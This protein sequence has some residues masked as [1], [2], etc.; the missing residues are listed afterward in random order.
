MADRATESNLKKALI[1]VLDRQGSPTDE[2]P[3][4]FNPDEY[5]LNKQVYH[6]DQNLPGRKTPVNQFVHGNA[7]SLSMDLFLDTYEEGTDVREYTD[8][9][10][11]LLEVDE[12]RHAP[13]VCRFVWGTLNFK[14]VLEQATMN[15]TMFRSNGI[16]VR[17]RVD[18]TF[19]EYK[20]PAEES[21]ARPRQSADR[22]KVWTVTEGDTLW[23]IAGEEYGDPGRWRPIA[24]ANDIDTPRTLNPGRD[25]VVPPLEV[26]R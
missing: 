22:T 12:E 1:Q 18:V 3:V 10:Q 13:P 5:S 25:L 24:K 15:F 2:I 19:K 20:N 16:P 7:D 8:R 14:S 26:E 11:E 4:L 6:S 23:R 21:T 9:I 17:A